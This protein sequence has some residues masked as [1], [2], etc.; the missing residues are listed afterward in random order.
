MDQRRT[1]ARFHIELRWCQS[2]ACSGWAERGRN[3]TWPGESIHWLKKLAYLENVSLLILILLE[4]G[5]SLLRLRIELLVWIPGNSLSQEGAPPLLL[6]TQ[7]SCLTPFLS[8]IWSTSQI[9]SEINYLSLLDSSSKPH[10]SKGL[11]SDLQ[12]QFQLPTHAA[13]NSR[14]SGVLWK[15]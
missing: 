11:L 4:I 3:E 7:A 8:D 2:G 12:L 5:S 9:D 13:L 6:K 1:G 10:D 15:R 14:A